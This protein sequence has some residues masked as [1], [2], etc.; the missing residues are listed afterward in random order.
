[1]FN[2]RAIAWRVSGA[3]RFRRMTR[4]CTPWISGTLTAQ[5]LPKR[6]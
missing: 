5:R 3:A 2:T 6:R 1:M 4:V